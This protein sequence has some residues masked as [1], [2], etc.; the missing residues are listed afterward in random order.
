MTDELLTEAEVRKMRASLDENPI[1]VGYAG[2][3][4]PEWDAERIVATLEHLQAVAKAADGVLDCFN[5]FDG[6]APKYCGEH[7]EALDAVLYYL[8]MRRREAE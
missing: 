7:I 1:V 8:K 6:E 3:T 5:E 4:R 2:L